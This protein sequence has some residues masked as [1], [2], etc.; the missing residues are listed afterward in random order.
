[1]WTLP[2]VWLTSI[3]VGWNIGANDAG[4][5]MGTTVGSGL[6]S[7][8]R[9]L[10]LVSVFAVLGA[11]FQ[12]QRVAETIGTGIVT[13]DLPVAAVLVSLAVTGGLLT[14]VTSLGLPVS[15]GEVIVG[16]VAGVGLAAG[17]E[18][19]LARILGIL[20]FWAVSP[21]IA[22]ILAYAVHRALSPLLRR[23]QQFHRLESL[24]GVLLLASSSYVAFS[25]GASNAGK[26]VGPLLRL[27]IEGRWLPL[28]GGAAIVGGV[29]TFGQRVTRTISGGIVQLDPLAAFSAQTSAALVIHFV[30]RLGIPISTS[31]AIVGAVVG[32][33]LLRGVRAVRG[34]RLTRILVGWV[35]TPLFAGGISFALYRLVALGA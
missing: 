30:S 8:R 27:G 28:L 5:C 3:Y 17:A 13:S 25:M 33:G 35:L 31:Q 34:R 15:T 10:L 9:A 4:N 6:L 14:L 16:A 26:A 11:A 32:V 21:L 1:M 12:G 22:G 24:L 29:V 19:S 23:I 20:Q 7:Y 2:A 18:V